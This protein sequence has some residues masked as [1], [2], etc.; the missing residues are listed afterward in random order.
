MI[1][2]HNALPAPFRVGPNSVALSA[3]R[4]RPCLQHHIAEALGNAKLQRNFSLGPPV[5]RSGSRSLPFY[6]MSAYQDPYE[7]R[8]GAQIG[9]SG[10]RGTVARAEDVGYQPFQHRTCQIRPNISLI[11]R[12]S[13]A[14]LLQRSARIETER[15]FLIRLTWQVLNISTVLSRIVA[16]PHHREYSI[17]PVP[18]RG[19]QWQPVCCTLEE[20]LS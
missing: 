10:C 16:T 6:V 9:R 14:R 13:F 7:M 18:F 2:V 5:P 1:T 3:G 19:P 12:I 20:F 15:T 4:R 11:T 8:R 17:Q